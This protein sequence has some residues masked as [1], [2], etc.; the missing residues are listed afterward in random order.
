M[1]A[2]TPGALPPDGTAAVAGIR[3]PPGHAISAAEGERRVTVAWQTNEP[4]E[5]TVL[6]T[7]VRALAEVFPA[8]GLWPI[9]VELLRENK[10]ERPQATAGPDRCSHSA[11]EILSTGD[12]QSA[13]WR[14]AGVPPFAGL[15]CSVPGSDLAAHD[16]VQTEAGA[17]LLVPA[18]RPADIP[19]AIG[20]MSLSD[21][22]LG[23]GGASTVL[24]SWEERFGAVVSSM[25]YDALWLQT[26]RRPLSQPQ[27]QVLATEHY[28]FC[29]DNIWGPEPDEYVEQIRDSDFWYFS[30]S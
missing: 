5:A 29:P 9:R 26:A 7:L 12:A 30:W 22:D 28:A 25:S 8:T 4:I 13:Y 24:R 14:E 6:Q 1:F 10:L 2:S 16:L 23:G 27:M 15:A 11:F 17:L 18:R 20:W 3:L 21:Y 19:S